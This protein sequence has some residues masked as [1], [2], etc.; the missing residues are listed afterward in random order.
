M[1]DIELGCFNNNLI[2][3][4]QLIS[5]EETRDCLNILDMRHFRLF[6]TVRK[7][8]CFQPCY[9]EVSSRNRKGYSYSCFSSTSSQANSD[10]QTQFKTILFF[11]AKL[12]LT[13]R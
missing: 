12:Y 1:K 13:L 4:K 5:M 7:S 11:P 8:I 6:P 9:S 10:Q 2:T 3:V